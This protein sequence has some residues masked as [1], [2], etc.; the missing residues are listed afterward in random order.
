MPVTG[1]TLF[2]RQIYV[3]TMPL[4]N[5][6]DL[7]LPATMLAIVV[8]FSAS[9][10]RGYSGFGF[11]AILMAGLLP[12]I[13]SAQLVPL[14]ILLEIIASASQA[15]RVLPDIDRRLLGALLG[16]SLVG[17]PLGVFLLNW[18]P[19]YILRLLVYGTIFLSVSVFLISR[20]RPIK[21]S[22]SRALVAGFAAGIVNGATALSGLVLALFFTS[23]TI[24][25]R[26]MR[27]TMIAYLFF[28]DV[29]TG[30]ALFWSGHYDHQVVWRGLTALPIMLAGLALGSMQFFKTPVENFKTR[31]MWLLLVLCLGGI[32]QMLGS[33]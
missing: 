20:V 26:T 9:Y 11:S 10:V 31:V 5:L 16:T 4:H 27:A 13:P 7:S 19:E 21:M 25:S 1:A 14:S 30:G 18:F 3:T 2:T 15:P 8:V 28:T 23:S 32:I 22:I 17:A 33:R 29:I 12:V 6:L 24:G